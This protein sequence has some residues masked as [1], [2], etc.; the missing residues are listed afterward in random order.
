MRSDA[1]MAAEEAAC[2][3]HEPTYGEIGY[4]CRNCGKFLF[5]YVDDR[6]EAQA[7]AAEA[8]RIV[9]EGFKRGRPRLTAAELQKRAIEII[10]QAEATLIA[11]ADRNRANA[12]SLPDILQLLIRLRTEIRRIE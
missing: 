9:D 6:P 7:L 1:E 2:N 3:E 10:D 4:E 8:R 12:M 5:R 11:A